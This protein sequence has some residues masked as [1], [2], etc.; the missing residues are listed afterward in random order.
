M[1]NHVTNKI[2]IEGSQEEVAEVMD[3]LNDGKDG[4]TFENFSPMPKALRGTPSPSRIVSESE[5]AILKLIRDKK[6]K[7]GTL[8]DWETI[9]LTEKLQ[10]E[11]IEKYGFDNWHDWS[12]ANWGTKWG[13]YDGIV[14]DENKVVFDTAWATPYNAMSILSIKYPNVTI[15]IDYADED[16]GHNVGQYIMLGGTELSQTTPEGGSE[17]AIRMALD[18]KKDDYYL[19]DSLTYIEEDEMEELNDF[20]TTMIKIAVEKETQYDEYPDH[21]IE[22]MLVLAVENEQFEYASILKKQLDSK[23]V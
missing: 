4:I 10:S 1:P 14:V 13:A 2:T 11:L 15:T 12:I 21:V 5:Y 17:E 3:I 8:N 23:K 22:Y 6:K 20:N 18:I 16:F 19:T 7:D 9:P